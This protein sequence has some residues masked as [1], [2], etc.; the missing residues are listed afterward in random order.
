MKKFILLSSIF[1]LIL[2]G[3][4]FI[5]C[6]I[7][8]PM[9]KFTL[10]VELPE[11]SQVSLLLYDAAASELIQETVHVTITGDDADKAMDVAYEP[12]KNME[13]SIGVT[14]FLVNSNY[15]PT[16]DDPISYNLIIES[17]NYVS[18]S[19]IVTLVSSGSLTQNIYLVRLDNPPA[20]VGVQQNTDGSSD[21]SGATTSEII[22]E[23]SAS[24]DVQS[25]VTIPAGTILTNESGDAL[26]GKLTTTVSC[27]DGSSQGAANTLPQDMK[28]DGKILQATAM[29]TMQIMDENGNIA[30]SSAGLGKKSGVQSGDDIT[31]VIVLPVD[32]L[33]LYTIINNALEFLDNIPGVTVVKEGLTC[34]ITG[35]ISNVL[36]IIAGTAITQCSSTP[37]YQITKNDGTALTKEDVLGKSVTYEYWKTVLSQDIKMSGSAS[38]ENGEYKISL[39]NINLSITNFII[40]IGDDEVYSE[41]SSN[42][43]SLSNPMQVD[44]TPP[45]SKTSQDFSLTLQCGS[46]G[47][48]KTNASLPQGLYKYSS[49]SSNSDWLS[50][51]GG[52]FTISDVQQEVYTIEFT[53]THDGEQESGSIVFDLTGW[54]TSGYAPSASDLSV[55]FDI[56]DDLDDNYYIEYDGEAI[57]IVMQI[58]EEN[59]EDY[60]IDF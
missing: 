30:G 20:G 22:V 25:Q 24:D 8:N 9:D 28:V 3:I 5:S 7:Q 51:N 53:V 27:Y 10:T 45:T 50:F 56:E 34:T 60:G 59:C 48:N 12:T 42:L 17:D 2:T 26:K 11:E 44:Y 52:N 46:D 1:V 37:E 43:C 15:F 19:K 47:N 58:S 23:T 49:A 6:D 57:E 29:F 33:V 16:S 54:G 41:V 31:I 13:T 32:N 21:A 4:F 39:P 40:F 55:N 18:T 35:P 38:T 14:S 36:N